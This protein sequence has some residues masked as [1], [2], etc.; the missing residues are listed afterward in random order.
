MTTAPFPWFGGKSL[1]AR[2]IADLLP[3]H[4]VY[5]EPFAGSAAVLFS[6]PRSHM[7][8]VND[9]DGGVVTFFR[10][11]R[12]RPGELLERLH[13]TPHA[14]GEYELCRDTWEAVEDDVERARRWYVT[15]SQSF[16]SSSGRMHSNGWNGEYKGA[17]HVPAPSAWVSNVRQLEG[18]AERF[19]G[20]QVEHRDWREVL[21]KYDGP[22]ACFYLD[23]PYVLSTRKS[24]GYRH[25]LSDDD[26]RELVERLLGL[27]GCAVV[28]G[29]DSPLYEPLERAPGWACHR[30]DALTRFGSSGNGRAKAA[31]RT[32]VIWRSGDESLLTLLAIDASDAER[33]A[34]SRAPR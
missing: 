18:A 12:D 33:R 16:S 26:H 13:L 29:Y 25:E 8:V 32:E 23:P 7:E 22:E 27:Q 15:I 3:P 34:P 20:V 24:G 9:L 6:K 28:S 17:S 19:R 10:V 31:R 1:L 2:R 14:R 30:F 11:L 5:V 4:R 21:E